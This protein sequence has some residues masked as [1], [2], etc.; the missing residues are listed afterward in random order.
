LN[1]LYKKICPKKSCVF[2]P[3]CCL[4]CVGAR[5]VFSSCDGAAAHSV[6]VAPLCFL[7]RAPFTFRLACIQRPHAKLVQLLSGGPVFRL[8]RLGAA[9]T[10]HDTCATRVY[11]LWVCSAHPLPKCCA[12]SGS[13]DSS[14]RVH[15]RN[16]KSACGIHGLGAAPK[17]H[18]AA[19]HSRTT[20]ECA[21]HAVCRRA[22][23]TAAVKTSPHA[24]HRRRHTDSCWGVYT[25]FPS[26]LRA[27]LE[28]ET[29]LQQ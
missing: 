12:H 13:A 7:Q 22:V 29:S 5:G 26:T 28:P 4:W 18:H 11:H 1:F 27:V 9:P 19:P 21:R 3:W 10:R 8:H 25:P 23:P 17:R 16:H 2:F 14:P 6:K 20:C 15:M 24:A